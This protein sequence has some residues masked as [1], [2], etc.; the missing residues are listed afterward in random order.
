MSVSSTFALPG[1]PDAGTNTYVPLAGDGYTAPHSLFAV[2][3]TLA[4]DASGGVANIRITRDPRWEHL[5]PVIGALNTNTTQ[6]E[7]QMDI[8]TALAAGGPI[9]LVGGLA[10]QRPDGTQA[11]V[12]TPPPIINPLSFQVVAANVDTFQLS[13]SMVV[14]NFRVDASRKIPLPI[15]LASVPT[16]GNLQ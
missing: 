6:D 15:L 7:M 3:V 16:G 13:M 5:V 10:Q 9:F 1:Q 8:T 4:M 11:R 12:W 14:Y 2:N